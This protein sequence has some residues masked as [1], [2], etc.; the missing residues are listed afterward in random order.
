MSI[1][2][3]HPTNTKADFKIYNGLKY[4]G[5]KPLAAISKVLMNEGYDMP[6]H[7]LRSCIAR[8]AKAG[9]LKKTKKGYRWELRICDSLIKSSLREFLDKETVLDDLMSNEK[10]YIC[11]PGETCHKHNQSEIQVGKLRRGASLL[12]VLGGKLFRNWSFLKLARTNK[13]E[14][15]SLNTPGP[16]SSLISENEHEE[17]PPTK[18]LCLGT[19]IQRNVEQ[20]LEDCWDRIVTNILGYIPS[21]D[22]LH[23]LDL[24]QPESDSDEEE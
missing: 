14:K 8:A 15:E 7:Q 5:G 13:D 16:S 6:M 21:T 18:K 9:L 24:S 12:S 23:R 11:G 19:G 4:S 20:E 17:Q 10:W 2:T 1:E 3:P 22:V